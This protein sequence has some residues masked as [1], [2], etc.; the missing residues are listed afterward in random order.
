M[1]LFRNRPKHR[2]SRNSLPAS[3]L[4]LK[5]ML[6]EGQLEALHNDNSSDSDGP[7]SDSTAV[8]EAAPNII[9]DDDR[10]RF[11]EDWGKQ[12]ITLVLSDHM[13]LQ[14][15][16]PRQQTHA[17]RAWRNRMFEASQHGPV[18]RVHFAAAAL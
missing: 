2:G 11:V 4:F 14:G 12:T 6:N 15:R 16:S 13:A 7:S 9:H 18:H 5:G 3:P 8:V 17:I 1:P 10:E